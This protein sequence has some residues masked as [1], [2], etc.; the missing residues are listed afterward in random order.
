MKNFRESKIT[1]AVRSTFPQAL[2]A[3]ANYEN[4]DG[5]GKTLVYPYYTQR[6]GSISLSS[7]V[8]SSMHNLLEK[9]PK[10]KAN[11]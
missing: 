11:L 2:N 1:S 9:S 3:S 5:L 4:N 6:S 8:T 7:T 10:I